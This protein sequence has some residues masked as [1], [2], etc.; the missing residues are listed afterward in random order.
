MPSRMRY[1]ARLTS[2]NETEHG[3]DF[4]TMEGNLIQLQHQSFKPG[5]GSDSAK[6][7]SVGS[8][9]E[10]PEPGAAGDL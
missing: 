4:I 1:I 9:L 6:N 3:N 2:S 8:A 10:A 5:M 7:F